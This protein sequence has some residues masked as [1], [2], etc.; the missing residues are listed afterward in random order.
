M[1]NI[2]KTFAYSVLPYH[3]RRRRLEFQLTLKSSVLK[4][5][6]LWTAGCCDKN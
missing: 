3:R 2:V 1:I 5:N 6:Q 4:L